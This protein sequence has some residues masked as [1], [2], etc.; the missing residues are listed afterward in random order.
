VYPDY[1]L[2]PRASPFLEI[3]PISGA[4]TLYEACG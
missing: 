3:R 4:V 2:A 1:S